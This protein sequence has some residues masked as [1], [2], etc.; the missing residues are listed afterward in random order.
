MS[1]QQFITKA[2]QNK[3]GKNVGKR[4]IWF[5][6]RKGGVEHCFPKFNQYEA[7][8]F[9]L[10]GSVTELVVTPVENINSEV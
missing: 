2:A 9:S 4:S 3:T 10:F 1:S 8:D 7:D 6:G 5:N